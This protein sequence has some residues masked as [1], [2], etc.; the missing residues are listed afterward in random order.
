M[1]GDDLGRFDPFYIPGH[2]LLWLPVA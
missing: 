1:I 2:A